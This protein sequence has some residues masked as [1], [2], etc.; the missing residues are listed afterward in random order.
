MEGSYT[1]WVSTKS[2]LRMY[3]IGSSAVKAS[4]VFRDFDQQKDLCGMVG[5]KRVLVW[6]QNCLVLYSEESVLILPGLASVQT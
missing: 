4:S 5:T 3:G 2:E 6:W 1:A